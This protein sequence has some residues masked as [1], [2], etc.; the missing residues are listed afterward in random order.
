MFDVKHC[1][2]FHVATAGLAK[3]FAY[4]EGALSLVSFSVSGLLKEYLLYLVASGRHNKLGI[5]E[6]FEHHDELPL[7]VAPLDFFV[8]IFLI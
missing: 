8:G 2:L 7:T 6:T 3:P 5:Q 4:K 1:S